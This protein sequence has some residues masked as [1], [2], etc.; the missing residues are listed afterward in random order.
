MFLTLL[1]ILQT[2]WDLRPIVYPAT[3]VISQLPPIILTK[4]IN[5]ALPAHRIPAWTRPPCIATI[6]T[7]PVTVSMVTANA[8]T[9]VIA[10][11][12]GV[13]LPVYLV[14]PESLLVAAVAIEA[15]IDTMS[16]TAIVPKVS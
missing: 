13:T 12:V 9:T 15:S 6:V 1:V 14:I 10:M 7:V 8:V 16:F 2:P 11:A 3:T 4:A 5:C